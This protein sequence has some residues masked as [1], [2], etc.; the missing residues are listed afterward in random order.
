VSLAPPPLNAWRD[1]P[2]VWAR[3]FQALYARV[4]GSAVGGSTDVSLPELV[5]D[6][7]PIAS[8]ASG[9]PAMNGSAAVGVSA[10]YARADHVHPTDTSRAPLAS[11]ALTG[12]PTAP[13]PAVGDD[14]T[15]IATTAFLV[16]ALPRAT[17][18]VTSGAP[19]SV[20]IVGSA[21]GIS[22][23]SIVT[24]NPPNARAVRFTFSAEMPDTN[25]VIAPMR[26]Y[27]GD[28]GHSLQMHIYALATTHVDIGWRSYTGT[29]EEI[30]AYTHRFSVLVYR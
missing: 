25:Y 28:G 7:P 18:G 10:R 27:T 14:S 6:L 2:T 21:S 29:Y 11:P 12:T 24:V 1:M 15:K 13:T 3:W 19:G 20:A 16:A 9:A 23:V 5:S 30:D 26:H 8:P 4:G 17:V 22:G